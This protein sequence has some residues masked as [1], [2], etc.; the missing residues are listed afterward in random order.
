MPVSWYTGFAVA[1]LLPIKPYLLNVYFG[2][3]EWSTG[4]V[5]GQQNTS[6]NNLPPNM[7]AYDFLQ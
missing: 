2:N 6:P 4:A 7:A 3:W 5:L 1:V